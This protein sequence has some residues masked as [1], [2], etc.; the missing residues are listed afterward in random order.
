MATLMGTQTATQKA[1]LTATGALCRSGQAQGS[2]WTPASPQVAACMA[3]RRS[4][5]ECRATQKGSVGWARG[6]G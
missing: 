3:A 5:A 1:M 2:D 6:R 4:G